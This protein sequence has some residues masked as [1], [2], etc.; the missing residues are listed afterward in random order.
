MAILPKSFE[1]LEKWAAWAIDTE[2]AR[3]TKRLSSTKEEILEF[4][5]AIQPELERMLTY[6]DEY[7]IGSLPPDA[8]R[9]FDLTLMVAEIACN[10]EFYGGSPGVPFSFEERR[11]IAVHGENRH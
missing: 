1:S 3:W 2:N 4:Y 7:P 8:A 6:C 10:A 9:L 5:S 11:L